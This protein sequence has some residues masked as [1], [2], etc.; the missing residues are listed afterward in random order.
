MPVAGGSLFGK[1]RGYAPARRRA[2]RTGRAP[3]KER[4]RALGD[5]PGGA[6]QEESERAGPRSLGMGRSL[7]PSVFLKV[8]SSSRVRL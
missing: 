6:A 7:R 8:Y 3:G 5:G 1:N 4:L 2:C